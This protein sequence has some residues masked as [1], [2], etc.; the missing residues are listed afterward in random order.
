[1]NKKY[2]FVTTKE[3]TVV[4]LVKITKRQN[5]TRCIAYTISHTSYYGFEIE[6]GKRYSCID[7]AQLCIALL[8]NGEL[9]NYPKEHVLSY[10]FKNS[11]NERSN[12]ARK[13]TQH[14]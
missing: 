14:T 10:V 2:I 1:M 12:N 8:Y 11:I 5:T 7:K 4:P 6:K 13:N 9:E 3:H